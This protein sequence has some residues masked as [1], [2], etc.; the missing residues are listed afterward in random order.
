[1]HTITR[2]EEVLKE[3]KIIDVNSCFFQTN[4]IGNWI[5]IYKNTT[6]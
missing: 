6:I 3:T 4:F 2:I 1:M 5:D